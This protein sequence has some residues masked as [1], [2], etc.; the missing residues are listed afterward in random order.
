[1]ITWIGCVLWSL[2]SISV[3]ATTPTGTLPVV[4]VNTQNSRSINDTETQIPATVYI[5]SLS[6]QF[7]SLGSAQQ[8]IDATIKGRGNWTWS[9]FDKKP[10]K[11]KF[12]VKHK[13][14]G[15]PNNRHWCLPTTAIGV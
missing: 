1:M 3:S 5:D 2:T 12:N 15:M 4:Y 6:P 11:L 14:L 7:R 9:G 8:P 10:Y 13:V